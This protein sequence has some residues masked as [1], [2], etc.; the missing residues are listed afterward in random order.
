MLAAGPQ[1]PQGE[2][3]DTGPQGA[4]G[5]TGPAGATGA[6][7]AT[8]AAG[9]AGATGA[10]GATGAQGPPGP[11]GLYLPDYDSG[12]INI[13]D[14]RG[15]P[16]NITHNLSYADVVVDITGKATA[17]GAVHQRLGLSSYIPRWNRTFGGPQHDWGRSLVQ[18][19]DGGY[20]VAGFTRSFGA[21]IEDVFLVKTDANG[22]ILW[23]KTYGGPNADF[24]LSMVQTA[25]GGY[26]IA[27]FTG[28][29]GAGLIDAYLIKTDA[30]GNLAWSKT[31]GGTNDDSANSVIQMSDGGYTIA[32]STSSF[33]AGLSD[34]FLFR[35]DANG[36]M[37]WNKTYGGTNDDYGYSV[38]QTVDG[39]YAIV[40]ETA[41]YG[42]GGLDVFLVKTDAIGV[43]QWNKTYGGADHD[44]GYSMV[45]ASDSGYA[46]AG[47][48]GSYGAGGYDAYLIKTLANGDMQ[49]NKTY[50]GPSFDDWHGIVKASGGGYALAGR[51]ILSSDLSD[52]DMVLAITDANGVMLWNK[53]WG[54]KDPDYGVSMVQ[55]ADGGYAIAGETQSFG[56]GNTDFYLVKT[57]AFGEFGLVR[58]D[59]ATNTVTLYRGLTDI[60]WNYVRV[61]IWKID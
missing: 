14:K 24:G 1:G 53:T 22:Y 18:T 27:G 46:I 48:T 33:G 2:K 31:Y 6:T 16:F 56:A 30:N 28:S 52:D 11:Q 23:N 32:G 50:G 40:G 3:G 29:F 17:T 12:W 60:Y 44:I 57:E 49:W 7:G 10:T 41:S 36:A 51:M 58:T 39:G 42:G 4:T 35:T 45:Q 54:G 37:L 25:D 15:Q 38:I 55:T 26:A 5:P 34:V 20:A 13:T 59:T 61:R 47:I 8:G 19:N 43:L 21:G 9:P